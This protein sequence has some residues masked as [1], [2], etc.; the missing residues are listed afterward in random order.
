MPIKF[1]TIM[2]VVGFICIIVAGLFKGKPEAGL[3]IW[4]GLSL[5]VASGLIFKRHNWKG[6]SDGRRRAK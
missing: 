6:S 4:S 5:L 2:M 3:F 1:A